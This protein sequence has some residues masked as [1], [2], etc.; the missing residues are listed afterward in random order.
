MLLKKND[1]LKLIFENAKISTIKSRKVKYIENIQEEGTKLILLKYMH[2]PYLRK[3]H[4]M[5]FFEFP[6]TH[7]TK[8]PPF[9]V[10]VRDTALLMSA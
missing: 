10:L 4:K 9:G 1:F 3:I 5:R 7:K 8:T 2:H 6:S